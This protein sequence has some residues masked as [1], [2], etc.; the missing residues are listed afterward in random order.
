MV[1]D[2]KRHNHCPS[3]CKY[4]VSLQWID[5]VIKHVKKKR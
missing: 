2:F 5:S 1:A 4:E 3:A